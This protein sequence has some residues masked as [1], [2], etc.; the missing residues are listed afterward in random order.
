MDLLAQ[1]CQKLAINKKIL[2]HENKNLRN[3]LQKERK[4][5]KWDKKIRLFLKNEFNQV[6]FFFPNKITALRKH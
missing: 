4:H 5:Q 2:E 1:A 3:I 6:M